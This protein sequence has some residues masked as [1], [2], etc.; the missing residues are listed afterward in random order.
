MNIKFLGRGAA[1]NP[2]EGSNSAY[3]NSD[4]ELFLI[5]AGESVYYDIARLKLL[6]NIKAL[7]I[8]ITHTHGDH[9]GSIGS[10]LVYACHVS[11]IPVNLIIKDNLY[12][13][14]VINLLKVFG[15]DNDK[16][17]ILSCEEVNNKYQAFNKVYYLKTMHTKKLDCYSII[18]ETNNG[19]I[20]YSG[21]TGETTLL[22]AFI[23]KYNNIDKIYMDIT[24]NPNGVVH[25]YIESLCD[26]VPE[27]LKNK[28]YCMH[29][30][31]QSAINRAL[32]LGFN[33]VKKEN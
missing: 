15:I 4:D 24:D 29:F 10:I 9:I 26:V 25:V 18:F 23:K 2:L 12:L 21:D 17:N 13:D 22:E 32:E 19:A 31:N 28:V 1:V 7:N 5:D 20:F 27:N 30:N 33:V 8:F 16:Y 14:S 6:D 11:K 3:F